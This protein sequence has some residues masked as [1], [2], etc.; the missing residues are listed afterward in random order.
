MGLGRT[1]QQRRDWKGWL[2]Q[3]RER[4]LLTGVPE[5]VCSDEQRWH[6]LLEEGGGDY[7]SGWRLEMLTLD[8]ARQFHGFIREHYGDP[9]YRGLLRRL[10]DRC[11]MA[12]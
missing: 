11:G 9:D 4:L 8:D 2:S 5:E 3:H 6:R 12:Q 7:P 1:K 10:E